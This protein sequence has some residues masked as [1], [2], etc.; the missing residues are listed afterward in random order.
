MRLAAEAQ[1]RVE[2]RAFT[3][4]EAHRA[5]EVFMT[6][7]TQLVMPIVRIDGEPVGDGR[8]GP[9]VRRLRELY[10]DMAAA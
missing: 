10:L 5:A 3:V 9:L 6:S 2:E 7:A 8:P 1:L 4:D